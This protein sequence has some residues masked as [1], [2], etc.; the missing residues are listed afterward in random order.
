MKH[1]LLAL[2][3]IT[4]SCHLAAQGGL[5]F[6]YGLRNTISFGIFLSRPDS[7]MRYHVG[8]THH[9]GGQLATVVTPAEREANYGLTP[10]GT[11]T[12]HYS[13]DFGFGYLLRDRFPIT[14]DIGLGTRVSYTNYSDTR[15]RDGGYT[16]INRRAT[17][18]NIGLAIGY[19]HHH[20]EPYIGYNT[21]RT[22]Y[23]GL[24]YVI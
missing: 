6:D 12:Y 23:I 8:Y 15:F 13:L 7:P 17:H 1:T 21:L 9:Y 19:R 4:A 24:R 14:A 5:Q 3:L 20:L 10:T 2:L 16:L 18:A 22:L 11:G